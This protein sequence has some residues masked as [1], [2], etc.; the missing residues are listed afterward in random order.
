MARCSRG[1]R[2]ASR[3]SAAPWQWTDPQGLRAEIDYILAHPIATSAGRPCPSSLR[4]SLRLRVSRESVD[5]EIVRPRVC[6]RW[7]AL[8][9]VQDHAEAERPEWVNFGGFPTTACRQLILR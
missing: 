8:Q 4:A 7:A 6:V 1:C 2:M 3:P 9:R 5:R